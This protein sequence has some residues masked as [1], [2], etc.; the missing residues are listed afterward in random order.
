MTNEQIQDMLKQVDSD[1]SGT[2]EFDEFCSYM[3]K[4]LNKARQPPNIDELRKRVFKVRLN[5]FNNR[6]FC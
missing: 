5:N 3:M 1:N 2:I 4:K 6:N